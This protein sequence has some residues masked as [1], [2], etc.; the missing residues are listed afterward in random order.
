MYKY[1]S[2]H[3]IKLNTFLFPLI[4]NRDCLGMICSG[5]S[6]EKEQRYRM[7]VLQYIR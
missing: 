2:S 4:L 6:P 5:I 3:D 1:V 7:H